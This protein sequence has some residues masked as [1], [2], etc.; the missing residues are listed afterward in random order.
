MLKALSR[1]YEREAELKGAPDPDALLPRLKRW[2]VEKILPRLSW[3]P[4]V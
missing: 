1:V 3:L 4:R 2:Y